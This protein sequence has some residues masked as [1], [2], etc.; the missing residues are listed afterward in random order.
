M[1]QV[2]YGG[3]SIKTVDIGS[4]V[5]WHKGLSSYIAEYDILCIIQSW[6][7]FNWKSIISVLRVRSFQISIHAMKAPATGGVSAERPV[8]GIFLIP[9]KVLNSPLKGQW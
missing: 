9:N 7:K 1:K 4:L 6:L 8:I 2:Q 5:L 3:Y